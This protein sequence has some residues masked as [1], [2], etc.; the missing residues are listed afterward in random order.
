MYGSPGGRFPRVY[1]SQPVLGGRRTTGAAPPTAAAPARLIQESYPLALCSRRYFWCTLALGRAQNDRLFSFSGPFSF[2]SQKLLFLLSQRAHLPLFTPA[3]PLTPVSL[4]RVTISVSPS[5]P[6]AV[7]VSPLPCP[8]RPVIFGVFSPK[9]GTLLGLVSSRCCSSLVAS[10][11]S[12]SDSFELRNTQLQFL[13]ILRLFSYCR[14]N[15]R[16]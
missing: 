6:R 14:G 10:I 8:F 1:G 2:Y 5:T 16:S 15:L 4:P 12:S 7:S 11:A 3:E 13:D 9:L